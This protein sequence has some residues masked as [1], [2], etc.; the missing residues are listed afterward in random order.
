MLI[1]SPRNL[2]LCL[3]S[4][5][6]PFSRGF[7]R[8][9]QLAKIAAYL[10]RIHLLPQPTLSVF[11]LK[12]FKKF[13]SLPTNLVIL[14]G[15][16]KTYWKPCFLWNIF[17]A[18]RKTR[19]T[20]FIKIKTLGYTSCFYVP[21]KHCCSFFKHYINHA[22]EEFGRFSESVF[23]VSTSL[24]LLARK[25]KQRI[26]VFYAPWQLEIHNQEVRHKQTFCSLT[27]KKVGTRA[28]NSKTAWVKLSNVYH[29]SSDS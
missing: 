29:I 5:E 14:D 23:W 25:G 26:L 12:V 7:I 21:I 16:S 20:C 17:E 4:Q 9:W 24:L 19:S 10:V 13:I 2:N 3:D 11:S 8:S 18:V 1:F 15:Y 6:T 28:E 22:R 27:E